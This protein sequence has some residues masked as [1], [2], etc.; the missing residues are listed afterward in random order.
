MMDL[1]ETQRLFSVYL[2]ELANQFHRVPGS[3]IFVRYVKSSYQNDPVRSA[4]ELFLFLFAVRYL[5]APKYSTKPGIVQ[6]SEEEIDDL[7][8][9]WT[10]EPLVG[11]P[12]A[13]EA[14]EV[15]KRTV[16]VG[17]GLGC[18]YNPLART[19]ADSSFCTLV[20]RGPSPSCRMAEQ[21]RISHPTTFTTLTATRHLRKRRS[22]LYVTTVSDLADP[23][24]STVLRM[25]T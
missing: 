21:L 18:C 25:Y 11:P 16:L 13:L 2:Q 10:P 22:R 12:S 5:L 9:D 15:E 23:R 8:E 17:Y 6:L 3:A 7:V 1:Q 14:A 4:V 20:P 19:F 24:V